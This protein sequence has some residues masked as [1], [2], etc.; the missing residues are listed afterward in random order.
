ME[1][2]KLRPIHLLRPIMAANSSKNSP[3]DKI[4]TFCRDGEHFLARKDVAL[5]N[6]WDRIILFHEW[7]KNGIPQSALSDKLEGSQV[8]YQL[9]HAS[10][11][12]CRYML[13]Y[14]SKLPINEKG[15]LTSLAPIKTDSSEIL[16]ENRPET[17]YYQGFRTIHRAV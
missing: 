17:I 8:N 5:W 9:K 16:P 11:A 10:K 7:E 4:K 15:E 2:R 14:L 6:A 3:S 13:V 12:I 1:G